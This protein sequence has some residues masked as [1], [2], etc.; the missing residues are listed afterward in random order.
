[1]TMH[2]MKTM[3]HLNRG[4][5]VAALFAAMMLAGCA[6]KEIREDSNKP[7][8]ESADGGSATAPADKSTSATHTADAAT[9][10]ITQYPATPPPAGFNLPW[11]DALP[12]FDMKETGKRGGSMTVSVIG[13]PKT[14]DPVTSNENTSS[15]VIGALFSG[16]VGYDMENQKYYPSMLKSLTVADDNKTWTATL[17]DGMKWSDGQPITADDLM[18]TQQ[19][20]YD[21]QI[22]NPAADIMKVGGQPLKFEKID[23]L[24]VK[25]TTA[26]PTG[27]IDVILAVMTPLPK[28]SLEPAYKA[29][30]FNTAMSVNIDPAKLVVSGPF[31]LQVYQPGERVVL[32][33]NEYYHRVDKNG[34]R[35]PYLDSLTFS[36]APDLD[37]M[38]AKFRAGSAD[39]LDH[40][41]PETVPDLR[42]AQES[43]QFKLYDNGPGNSSTYFWF[44]L[45]PGA[46]ASG[47]PYVRPE[48]Q[49]VFSNPKFRRAVAMSI[50]RDGMINT[51]L[52]GLAVKS[53]S[54]TPAALKTWHNPHLP[55][56]EYNPDAARAL[57]DDLGLKVSE[58]D[59]I[60]HLPNGQPLAFKFITNVENKTR[61]ELSTIIATDLRAVGIQAT[62]ESVDFNALVTQLNDTF[63]YE[64]CLLGFGG[65]IHPMSSMNMWLS[66]GRTHT[67]NPLQK[68]PATP[69][70]AEVDKLAGEFSQALSLAAQQK[71]IF[72]MQQIFAENLPMIPLYT[73]KEFTAIRTKFGNVRPTPFAEG[74]WNADELY[75]K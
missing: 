5:A 3:G 29:G 66:T 61:T 63:Q 35:L 7:A 42:T 1:M 14:F 73:L 71:A 68:T 34:Q 62:P 72:Q 51:V 10:A 11:P 55:Q 18:F 32:V 54:M 39:E 69:W 26:E 16:L 25:I 38:T 15:Q 75:I 19:V 56:I 21:P 46:N 53:D 33:R 2:W 37:A 23:N 9:T 27:F 48:L 4:T 57:L 28:H 12:A 41:R 60:R 65:S 17:R 74:F 59:G 64:A 24:S 13:E 43:E 44:N 40:P 31:K 70:E 30:T 6:P 49:E 50:N 22:I 8:A 36:I 45:K 67:W 47:Q 58:R 20:I 52:R